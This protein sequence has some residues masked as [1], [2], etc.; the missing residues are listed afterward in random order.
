MSTDELTMALLISV[1]IT[2]TSMGALIHIASSP[3][4]DRGSR[5]RWTG[6]ILALPVVG[7]AFWL[8]RWMTLRRRFRRSVAHLELQLYSIPPSTSS[9]WPVT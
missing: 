9:T 4:L 1:G 5:E 8:C 3:Y 6:A 2:A 7:A